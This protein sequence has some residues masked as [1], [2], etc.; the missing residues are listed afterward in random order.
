M[1]FYIYKRSRIMK[2]DI[3]DVHRVISVGLQ[4]KVCLY[5]SI[6]SYRQIGR[7]FG[8]IKASNGE[9]TGGVTGLSLR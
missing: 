5:F 1:F 3:M 4:E 2:D 9:L 8:R 6:P 7:S